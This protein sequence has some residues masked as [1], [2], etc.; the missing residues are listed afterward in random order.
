[1]M[2]PLFLIIFSIPLKDHGLNRDL[3][4]SPKPVGSVFAHVAREKV[5]HSPGYVLSVA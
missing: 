5:I 4:T 1:M 3:S 2:N